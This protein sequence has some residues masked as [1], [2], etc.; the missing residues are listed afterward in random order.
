MKSSFPLLLAD[1]TLCC[2]MCPKGK[3]SL[4]TGISILAESSLRML[5][6]IDTK[7]SRPPGLSGTLKCQ[8]PICLNYRA[9]N[10]PQLCHLKF[11]YSEKATKIWN[12][13]YY[14]VV[15]K[16]RRL[17]EIFR[18]FSECPNFNTKSE[19]KFNFHNFFLEVQNDSYMFQNLRHLY[20]KVCFTLFHW[21]F[22]ICMRVK[23]KLK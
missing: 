4:N 14:A 19:G 5:A 20:L 10:A 2:W 7:Y 16:N 8:P 15:S 17:F 1:G 9:C 22:N 23:S 21:S 13:F 6:F 18:A 12:N 11:R 3:A